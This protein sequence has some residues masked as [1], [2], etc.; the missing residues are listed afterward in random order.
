MSIENER[1]STMTIHDTEIKAFEHKLTAQ[2][3]EAKAEIEKLQAH[4]K[5]KVAQAEI[6]AIHRLREKRLEIEKRHHE[7]KTAG[8]ARAAQLKAEIEAEMTKFKASLD[9]L[10]SKV[11]SHAATA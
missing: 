1:S 4:G 11:R 6:D 5:G 2:L 3:D 9:Q 10:A 7:L 8:E